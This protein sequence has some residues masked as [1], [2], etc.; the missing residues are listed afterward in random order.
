MAL[1]PQI[2]HSRTGASLI[3]L[4]LAIAIAGAV[5][6][7]ILTGFVTSR[8]GRVEQQQRTEAVTVLR[9][10]QEALRSVRERGWSTFANNGTFHPAIS[11]GQWTLASGVGVSGDY[12]TSVV[13]SDVNRDSNNQIASSG[14][15]LDPSTKRIDVSVTWE[16]PRTSSIT[17]TLYLTRYLDNLVYVQTTEAD[18]NLDTSVQTAV[19]NAGGGAVQLG[20]NVKAKWCSPSFSP[21]TIDLPDGPPVAVSATASATSTTIPNDVFVAVAPYAS[22]STKLAYL[23]VAAN[24]DP[25]TASLRGT[26]TLDAAKYSNASYV[27]TGIGLDNNFKTND[28]RYY[29]S[30]SGKLYALIATNLPDKEVIAILIDDNNF[31]DPV[32]K[33]YKYSTFFNTRRYQGNAQSLPNQDETPFGYGGVSLAVLGSRGYL[34]A[35]GFLYVIDLSTIDSKSTSSGLDEI[36]CR[37]EMDGYDC[38]PGSGTD[39]KYSAGETG[40]SWSTTTSAA[41]ADCSDGGNIELYADN[42]LYPVQVGASTYVYVAVGAGTNPEFNI[43][44]VTSVPTNSTSPKISASGCG[45]IASGNASWKRQSSYDFNTASGTEEA[46][47]SVFANSDGTRAYISSNGGIDG[48]SDGQADSKQFYILNTS[49]K[50]SPAFLSGSPATG[51]TSG[52]YSGSSTNVE[53]HPRRSLTVLNGQ[54]VVLV[55]KD[56]IANGNDAEEYQVLNSSSEASPTYCAG[57]NYDAGFNDLT[58]VTEADL[59]NF[60][61]MVANTN[62]K[63]LKIIQGGPDGTYSDQGTLESATLNAGYKTAFNRYS[64]T[65][66]TPTNTALSFQ[67]AGAD[68]VAGSCTGANYV[69]TGPDGTGSTFYTATTSALALNASGTGYKNPAQCFRYKAFFST[70][71]YNATAVLSD[72]TVNY[73][74]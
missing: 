36:G 70:I 15:T 12:T 59:D 48:N 35:G 68:P 2:S 3:E 41:H 17:S 40:A 34:A 27:P 31:Q 25:P 7:A 24:V 9:R 57:I 28:V 23:N 54:R 45:T 20:N 60:V 39:R 19:T 64:A 51:P 11:S 49:N 26:F 1:L 6:P 52:Y 73:S 16:I 47:N 38:N 65:L 53:M 5:L 29:K 55:G 22:S 4:L 18:F 72:M 46:A 58:S 10:T 44:N 63:Q 71:D 14:G 56:A 42:D 21:A 61:Y 67:F 8:Q 37:I 32:S 62:E 30:G 66:T 13:I 43:V 69:F 74:P 50:S 33:I